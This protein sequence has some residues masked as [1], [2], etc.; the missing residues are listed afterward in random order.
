ML[1]HSQRITSQSEFLI[2]EFN[3]RQICFFDPK[4]MFDEDGSPSLLFE[5]IMH[6]VAYEFT[7]VEILE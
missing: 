5:G 1:R 2:S 6:E 7:P 3:R 4:R